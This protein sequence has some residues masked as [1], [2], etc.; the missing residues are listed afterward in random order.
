MPAI[1]SR[2]YARSVVLLMFPVEAS[3]RRQAVAAWSSGASINVAVIG[4][5]ALGGWTPLHL[6]RQ[7]AKVILLDAWGR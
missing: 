3:S 4:A 2:L 7:G 1:S 6:L 5:G